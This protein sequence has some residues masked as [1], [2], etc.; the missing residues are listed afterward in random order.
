MGEREFITWRRHIDLGQLR[1][2][3]G[4]E[5]DGEAE[6]I[7][8]G[9]RGF[10]STLVFESDGTSSSAIYPIYGLPCKLVFP[11]SAILH[12]FSPLGR[13]MHFIH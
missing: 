8:A 5:R 2:K 7:E 11:S 12:W 4:K 13:T 3:V 10:I 1:M 6:D 9:R